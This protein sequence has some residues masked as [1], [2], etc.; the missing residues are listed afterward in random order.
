[1]KYL[2]SLTT[3]EMRKSQTIKLFQ[4]HKPKIAGMKTFGLG[5]YKQLLR[6]VI[7]CLFGQRKS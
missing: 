3:S 1:M 2:V 6:A 7:L 4:F 5:K